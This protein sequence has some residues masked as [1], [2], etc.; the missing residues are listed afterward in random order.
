MNIVEE[1]MSYTVM[2]STCAM[3]AVTLATLVIV[4]FIS[5]ASARYKERYLKE[6]SV[7]LDDV[8]LQMPAEK[9]LDLSLALSAIVGFIVVLI[10]CISYSHWSWTKIFIIGIL[11]TIV[12]FPLPRLILRFLKKRRLILFNIQLEDALIS[13]SSA[14]KAGF[15]INQA[16][17]VIAEENIRPISIEFRLLLQEIRLGVPLEKALMNMVDRIQSDD[18]DLVATAIITARQTGG[19]LTLIL[20]RLAAVIRERLRIEGRLRAL[21]AQGKLQAYVIAAMPALLMFAVNYVAPDMMSQF[22]ESSAGIPLLV[23]AALMILI[24]FTVIKKITT[25]DI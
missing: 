7:E 18:L 14:L 15:S 5:Y 3:L 6:A 22:F 8:L 13:M 23:L 4:D 16:L 20:E 21:T 17:E 1:L 10:L 2:A 11:T 12:T 25:I 24:G 9:I 19:E